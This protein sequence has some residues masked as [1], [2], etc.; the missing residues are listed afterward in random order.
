[1]EDSQSKKSAIN[2]DT[3]FS[4]LKSEKPAHDVILRHSSQ[5]VSYI[6]SSLDCPSNNITFLWP[7]KWDF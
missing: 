6:T 3:L 1:M 5:T 2:A 4:E 7:L